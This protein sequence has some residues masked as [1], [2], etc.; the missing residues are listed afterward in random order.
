MH[1]CKPALLA[2]DASETLSITAS[3]REHCDACIEM[4]VGACGTFPLDGSGGLSVAAA[5]DVEG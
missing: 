3:G 1:T 5:T 4:P 2:G